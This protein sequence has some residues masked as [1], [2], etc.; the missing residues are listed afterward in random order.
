MLH[1]MALYYN[2]EAIESRPLINVIVNM[3]AMVSIH[4]NYLYGYPLH[5]QLNMNEG[6]VVMKIFEK[7]HLEGKLANK[8]PAQAIKEGSRPTT[9]WSRSCPN[10]RQSCNSFPCKLGIYKTAY[11]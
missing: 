2:E 1:A 7:A 4:G 6:L 11:I 9:S 10:S 8:I 5:M 3:Y